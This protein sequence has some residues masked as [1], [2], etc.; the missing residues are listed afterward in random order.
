MTQRTGTV[1]NPAELGAERVPVA[2]LPP[3]K[4]IAVTL[5]EYL[6]VAE[7]FVVGSYPPRRFVLADV[8]SDWPSPQ[9]P[10]RYPSAT[11]REMRPTRL[12][13]A[14]WGPT[15]LEETLDAFGAGTVL[16]KL[17]EAVAALTLDFWTSHD[18]ERD[19]ISAALPG[20]FSPGDAGAVLLAGPAAYWCRTVRAELIEVTDRDSSGLVYANERRLVARVEASVDV[21]ELR[22]ATVLS[23]SFEVVVATE[24]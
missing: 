16:Y 5:A 13:A 6:A 15:A 12:D 21:V 14:R 11:V 2:A 18:V 3:G 9:G 10:L 19:A 4:A 1:L 7:F 20:L 23:P 8:S 24:E 17:A 22:R